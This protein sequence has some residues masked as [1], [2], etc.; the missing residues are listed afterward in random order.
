[1]ATHSSLEFK[2]IM[3]FVTAQLRFR[4]SVLKAWVWAHCS[5][6]CSE[7]INNKNKRVPA[8]S[9]LLEKKDASKV[10]QIKNLDNMRCTYD[11][12]LKNIIT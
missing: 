9:L 8:W 7:K 10:G 4:A 3:P 1:M 11:K 2:T 12:N 6:S 5:I